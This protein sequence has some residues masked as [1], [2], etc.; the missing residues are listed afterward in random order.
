MKYKNVIGVLLALI[1]V[2]AGIFCVT[3]ATVTQSVPLLVLCMVTILVIWQAKSSISS[4]NCRLKILVLVTFIYFFLRA[5]FSAVSDL[6]RQDLFLMSSAMMIYCIMG[7]LMPSKIIRKWLTMAFILLMILNLLNW[8]PAIGDWRDSTLNFA[9]GK[10]NTGLFNHR[11]FYGNFMFMMTCLCLS[12]AVFG[13]QSSIV[14]GGYLVI[15]VLGGCSVVMS[16]SRASFLSLAIGVSVIIGCWMLV[17]YF[18]SDKK[19]KKPLAI[20]AITLCGLILISL[21]VGGKYVLSER[22]NEMAD[23]NG[24]KVYFA[25]SLEQVPDAP[26]FGSGSRSVEYKSYEYWPME[27]SRNTTDFKFVHNEYL[28]SITDYG[29]IGFVLLLTTF[30]W[31]LVNGVQLLFSQALVK[32]NENLTYIVSG[33]SIMLGLAINMLFSFPLHGFINLMFIVFVATMLLGESK[34]KSKADDQSRRLKPLFLITMITLCVTLLYSLTEGRKEFLAGINFWKEKIVVDDLHWKSGGQ[35]D[36]KWQKALQGA[37]KVSPTFERHNR[38]G[39]ILYAKGDLDQA[40]EHYSI[41]KEKHPYSPLSRISLARLLTSKEDFEEAEREYEDVE[42]LVKNREPL[43]NYYRNLA[44]FYLL[45]SHSESGLRSSLLTKARAACAMSVKKSD[46]Y[47]YPDLRRTMEMVLL[48]SYYDLLGSEQYEEAYNVIDEL[49]VLTRGHQI[50]TEADAKF[51]LSHAKEL[52]KHAQFTWS[53]G[54]LARAAKATYRAKAFYHK[55]YGALK[56]NVDQAW[57]SEEKKIN[58]ALSVF[59]QAGIKIDKK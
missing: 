46:G 22:S 3:F 48:S 45:W 1:L 29:I 21:L 43:F 32:V 27:M 55:Y 7:I 47:V 58:E 54:E 40:F 57:V 38:L 28:Q 14:R 2:F 36:E 51:I 53:K 9:N 23:S 4:K 8:I 34:S 11:N 24:R 25:L 31:H 20:L 41:S 18:S 12:F 52:L 17:H 56:G 39:E 26:L 49:V 10:S 44:D 37:V 35:A 42:Y 50:K 16:T 15:S 13:K 33:L 6:G 30:F 19:N 59:I 5:Y